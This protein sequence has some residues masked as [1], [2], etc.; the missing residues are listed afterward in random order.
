VLEC[1]VVRPG[2]WQIDLLNSVEC[3]CLR[4]ES[5]ELCVSQTGVSRGESSLRQS[6]QEARLYE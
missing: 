6:N 1:S 3:R 2:W 4:Q 5:W